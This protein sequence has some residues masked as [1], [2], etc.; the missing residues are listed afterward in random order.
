MVISSRCEG[1]GGGGGGGTRCAGTTIHN[2]QNV[3][4][5][6]THAITTTTQ[7]STLLQRVD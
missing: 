4:T 7:P 1:G 5:L 3:P 2:S 6:P